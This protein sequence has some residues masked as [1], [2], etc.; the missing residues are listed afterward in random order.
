MLPMILMAQKMPKKLEES[1]IEGIGEKFPDEE[2]A[3]YAYTTSFTFGA[4]KQ[5][6]N[7]TA[8]E[9]HDEYYVN[10]TKGQKTVYRSNYFD[11]TSMVYRLRNSCQFTTTNMK[12]NGLFH[13][14]MKLFLY[15]SGL[16]Y[17]NGVTNVSIQKKYRDSRYLISAYFQMEYPI[18][19]R[20]IVFTIPDNIEIELKEFNFES[21]NIEKTIEDTKLGKK[22]TY[23]MKDV[24][25]FPKEKNGP[26]R[27]FFA[28][29]VVIL[30]KQVNDAKGNV[31]FKVL[32]NTQ[33]QYDWYKGLVVDAANDRESVKEITNSI[34]KDCKTDKEKMEKI[35]YWAQDNIQYIAFEEGIAGFQPANC[36][37]V[38]KERYGDCKGMANLMTE[39]LQH[40]NIDARRTWIGTNSIAYDYSIPSLAVDN[41]AICTVIL[42]G[43]EYFLDATEEYIAVEDY[44]ERIQGRQVLIEDGDNYQLKE[45][46]SFDYQRNLNVVETTFDIKETVLE[47]SINLE[48]NGESKV[49]LLRSYHSMYSQYKEEAKNR[50]IIKDDNNIQVK[51][52]NTSDF[53]DRKGALSL[54]ASVAVENKVSKFGDELYLDWDLYKE[55]NEYD[56]DTTRELDYHFP[57][58]IYRLN[59]Y[60]Y[61]TPEGYKLK[62]YPS[63]Y[64]LKNEEFEIKVEL[65]EDANKQLKIVKSII[66]PKAKISVENIKAWNQAMEELKEQIYEKTIIYEKI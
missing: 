44:A 35:F 48:Y 51:E 6:Q 23:E 66:I 39:M 57:R 50:L 47:G 14:D 15:K 30:S 58:K 3:A 19:D 65:K 25:K 12:V 49:R 17:T 10:L 4:D 8:I 16:S 26:G 40:C 54:K 37:D 32:S 34:V 1:V 7:I 43:K 33:D 29:H 31:L 2:I 56:I 52:V 62:D 41:H 64:E 45:V 55:L 5:N 11:N 20:K 28:P 18:V 38:L 46:P 36:Q 13:H 63:N 22:I 60:T 42:D 61:N 59:K 9:T 53:E 27:T 21:Y 24:A